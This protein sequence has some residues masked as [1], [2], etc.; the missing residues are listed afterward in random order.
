MRATTAPTV[1]PWMLALATTQQGDVPLF[2]QALDGKASNKA[3][4]VAAVEALA[5][6]LRPT[7][8]AEAAMPIFVADSGLYRAENVT[9]LNAAGVRLRSVASPTLPQ[10]R[11]PRWSSTTTPGTRT[12]QCPGRLSPQRPQASAG[13]CRA[14][15][16]LDS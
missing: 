4:L 7:D 13:R 2:C 12:A 5:E 10:R 8:E 9:R 6:Q 11:G 3:S 15:E 16:A 1:Q 14:N